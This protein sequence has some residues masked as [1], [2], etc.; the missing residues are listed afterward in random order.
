MK[1]ITKTVFGLTFLSAMGIASLIPALPLLAQVYSVP[2]AYSSYLIAAFAL[3]GLLCIPFTGILA[4]RFGRKAVLVPS[5]FIY[6]IGGAMCAIA[7]N[8]TILLCC[9]FVQ[10]IGGSCFSLMYSTIVAD[11]WQ[12]EE[13]A[14]MMSRTAIATGLSSAILPTLGGILA[15]IHWRLPLLLPLSALPIAYLAYK[16]PLAVPQLSTNLAEYCK[17]SLHTFANPQTKLLLV[18]TLLTFTM[19]GGPIITCFPQ[20]AEQV[21]NASPT[22]IG[23][24]IASASLS[25]GAIASILPWLYKQTSTKNILILGQIAY[26][27]AFISLPFISTIYFLVIPIL[28]FGAGQGLTL[29]LC[30]TLLAG[31]TQTSQRAMLMSANSIT[32]R[33]AQTLSPIIFGLLANSISPAYA[34]L[35]GAVIPL[36]FLFCITRYSLP[37]IMQCEPPLSLDA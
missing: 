18:L 6:A 1:T 23:I 37:A 5:L 34:I 11:T 10:G 28:F 9:R 26:F 30:T 27:C 3:P 22:V 32:V 36:V 13:R 25:T 33:I 20:L 2:I 21:F 7:P 31:Q 24:I 19:L 17:Q 14:T 4:D 15:A 12:N 29:P 8:F 16:A 35:S